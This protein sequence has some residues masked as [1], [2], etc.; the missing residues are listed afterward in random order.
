MNLHN[1]GI[2]SAVLAL[3][4]GAPHAKAATLCVSSNGSYPCYTRI[5]DAVRA[6][7]PGDTIQVG[8]GT[9][10]E[11]IT[12]TK[13]LSLTTENAIVDATG[14]SRGFFID[15]LSSP[16]LS[17]VTIS[18]F[19]IRNAN[20]EGVLVLNS[21]GVTISN[22]N[23]TGN[24][25]GLTKGTCRG[26][27]AFETNESYDCGEG[28]HLMGADH[29]VVTN[30]TSVGNSGGIL[31]SDDTGATH[32]NLVSFNNVSE[33][34]YACGITLASHMPYGTATKPTP[35][36][37]TRYAYGVYNNTVYGNRATRNG[38]LNGG[39]S[40]LGIFASAPGTMAY[41]NVGVDNYL[42]EN[43]LPGIALHAHAPF[44]N[45]TDNMLVGNTI[46]SNG[47]DYQDATTP[48]PTGV[49]IYSVTPQTGNMV[50][51]NHISSESY[52]VA[53]N[54]PGVPVQVQYNSLGASNAGVA[55]FGAGPVIA[56]DNWWNCPTGPGASG[57][58]CA[59]VFGPGVVATPW[60]KVPVPGQPNF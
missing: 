8:P 42:A 5:A 56:T 53:V 13:P 16:G 25:K 54:M 21:S 46:V 48:G 2:G 40:G 17:N 32:N 34:P 37:N 29:A 33:N 36:P 30:N 55:N 18:G 23:V 28:I 10:R 44:Q 1:L 27:D 22:N 60:L 51:D 52:G 14:L 57:S 45:L 24:N 59:S 31:L 39:G 9:Y 15:G 58:G 3:L 19:A 6:A 38:L 26:L 7:A 4:A 50:V 11:S 47:A 43:G 41:G 35:I 12:I 20:F 49:N